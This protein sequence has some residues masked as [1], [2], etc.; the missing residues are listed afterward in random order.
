MGRT[1]SAHG[2]V[3][4]AGSAMKSRMTQM[5]SRMSQMKSRM[6]Q[7]KS[8]MTQFWDDDEEGDGWVPP[9]NDPTNGSKKRGLAA[10]LR[11]KSIRRLVC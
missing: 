11:G 8:R 4:R 3:M 7:M 2:K 5:K 6:S 9:S 1:M 10:A